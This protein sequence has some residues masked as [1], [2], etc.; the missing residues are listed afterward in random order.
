MVLKLFQT[1]ALDELCSKNQLDLLNS[2]DCLRSQGISHYVSLS[3]IIV[4]G[5]QSSEKSFVLKTISDVSFSVKSNL[6][7][8]F[9][10]KLIF[11][12][13]SQ[14]SVSVS[15]VSHQIRIE[16]E[17]FAFSSF[18]EQLKNFKKISN[19]IENAKTIMKILIHNKVFSIFFS[20]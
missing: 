4:C 11:R 6:S 15:I 12:K 14:T 3:Q 2:V 17:R 1:D 7:T 8:R 19:L 5:D 9:F 13:T 16:S 20:N 18:H 10:T